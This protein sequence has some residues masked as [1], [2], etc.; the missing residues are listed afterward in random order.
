MRKKLKSIAGLIIVLLIFAYL[1]RN[2]VVNWQQIKSFTWEINAIPLIASFLLFASTQLFAVWVW[3]QLLLTFGHR[4][5]FKKLFVIWWL[6]AMGRYLPG[7]VWQLVGLAVL[8]EKEGVPAEVTTA[9]SIMSQALAV[10]AGAVISVPILATKGQNFLVS[11]VVFVLVLAVM[12]Y[13]PIF[14]KWV[15]FAGKKFR[16]IE[17]PV[18]L[19]MLQIGRFL[20]LYGVIW[21]GYGLGFALFVAGLTGSKI[22]A[23]YVSIYAF[24]YIVGLLAIFVPGGFGVRE[25]LMTMFLSGQFGEGVASAISVAARLWVTLVEVLFF[26]IALYLKARKQDEKIQGGSRN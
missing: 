26:L 4:L 11:S 10:L 8:G 15:N 21:V 22:F 2:I 1:L 20:L 17:I 18:Y 24:S 16:G 6:S 3:R 23:I 19:D 25:G 12:I 13:P 9:A 7:K 14:R 5:E